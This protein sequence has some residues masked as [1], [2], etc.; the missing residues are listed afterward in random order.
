VYRA[1]DEHLHRDVS[2]K[3]LTER[4]AGSAEQRVGFEREARAVAALSHPNIVTIFDFGRQGSTAYAVSELLD[5][6]TLLDRLV[7]REPLP[8]RDAV[9]IAVGVA[10]GLA[11]AHEKG[12][13]HRDVKPA[14]VFLTAHGTVKILDFGL[15]R[16]HADAFDSA[17]ETLARDAAA[18][19]A[20]AVGMDSAGLAPALTSPGA[21]LGTTGYMSPEQARREMATPRSDVF[22][23][24]CVLYEMLAGRPPFARGSQD[25]TL[26]AILDE[27][28]SALQKVA[29]NSPR[30]VVALLSKCLAKDP[31]ARYADAGALLIDLETIGRE[32]EEPPP[33]EAR[34]MV[35]SLRRPLVA[36]LLLL[37]LVAG[38]FAIW[39]WN[40][41]SA[42]D[43]GATDPDSRSTP[44][45]R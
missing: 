4:L 31:A 37:L 9:A 40:T 17:A 1:H 29:A 14:N 25:D 45:R 12:I 2:L 24:G 43:P 28:P 38:A 18:P 41:T 10:R 32:L 3:V 21:L 42:G 16:L 36:I 13:V 33:I 34:S 30:S 39:R 26:Q 5:G 44:T 27:E 6:K 35:A 22:A 11:A 23:L 20:M 8:V 15:A 19:L 7:A